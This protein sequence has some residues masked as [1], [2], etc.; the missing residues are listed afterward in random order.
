[1]RAIEVGVGDWVF[2]ARVDGPPDGDLVLLLHG[3]PESS[4]EWTHVLGHL[5]AAG[6]F[7][8]APD[9]RGYSP[10]ARP[11]GVDSYHVS[12]LAEDVLGLADELGSRV[13]HL[14]G[15]DWGALVAWYVAAH[16]PDRVRTLTIVSVPHPRPFAD[17]RADDPDQRQRSEYI[18]TLREPEVPERMF[19]D[20]D[21][22]VLR[23]ALAEAGPEIVAEHVRV[24]TDPGAMTAA[25][26]YYRTWDD[27]LDRLG[28]V[29]TPT[30]FVW[31]T[32]DVALGR[33]PAEATADWVTGPYRFEVF[34]GIS[35]WI[36]EVAPEELSRLVLAHLDSS[37]A[38]P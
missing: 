18:A 9:Q 33:V 16:H 17:A 7:A 25:L 5:A 11:V 20:N 27:A 10:G 8:V 21:S 26:N 14:I 3:F 34:E 15:H 32:D 19:L 30:L 4:A 22:A 37:R 13:F 28:P 35:H 6:Y 24:L 29:A 2:D 36:P 23:A 31:S 12:R 38:D 1:M